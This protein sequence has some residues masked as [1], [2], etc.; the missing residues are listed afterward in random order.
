M[1]LSRLQLLLELENGGNKCLSAV[2]GIR[3][4]VGVAGVNSNAV[5]ETYR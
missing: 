4:V 1:L 5:I 2:W 3:V